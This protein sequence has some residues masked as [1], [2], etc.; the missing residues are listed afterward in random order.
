MW[1][2]SLTLWTRFWHSHWLIDYAVTVSVK[3]LTTRTWCWLNGYGLYNFTASHWL[4]SKKY[5]AEIKHIIKHAYT[6]AIKLTYKNCGVPYIWLKFR[7][8]VVLHFV[9]TELYFQLSSRILKTSY[10]RLSLIISGE[11]ECFFVT[12]SLYWSVVWSFI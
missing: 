4:Y 5:T 1:Q 3:S 12:L 7:Y 2:Q 11:V 6:K 9:I 10:N 8:C